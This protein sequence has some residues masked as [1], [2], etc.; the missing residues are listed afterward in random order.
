MLAFAAFFALRRCKGSEPAPVGQ[1]QHIRLVDISI[2]ING[3][4]VWRIA[5][6]VGQI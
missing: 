6:V 4:P 3:M 1:N 5:P 2:V